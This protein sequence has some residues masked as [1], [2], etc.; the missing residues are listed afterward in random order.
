MPRAPLRPDGVRFSSI[1]AAVLVSMLATL[2]LGGGVARAA[3]G[4]LNTGAYVTNGSVNAVVTAPDGSTYIGGNFS[5]VGPRIGEGFP[6][7]ESPSDITPTFGPGEP[8]PSAFPEVSGG[9]VRAVVADGSGG[10]YIGGNFDHVGGES[11]V[12]LAH[13]SGDGTVDTNWNASATGGTNGVEALAISAGTLYVAGDFTQVNSTARNG[14]AAV[15]TADPGSLDSS[16]NPNANGEVRALA[17]SPDSLTVYAAGAFTS[18]GGATRNHI[19]ALDAAGVNGGAGNA[20]SGWDPNANGEVHALAV[21]SGGTVYAGGSFN[22]I[23]GASRANLAALAAGNGSALSAWSTN[24][25]TN[26]SVEALALSPSDGTVFAGGTFT[27]VGGASHVRIAALD[28][29]NGTPKSWAPQLNGTVRALTISG[30]FVYAGGDFTTVTDEGSNTRLRNHV[31]AISI[32]DPLAAASVW[33]PNTDAAAIALAAGGGRV[34]IGGNFVTAGSQVADRDNL[35]R[36]NADGTLDTGWAP[37]GTDGPVKALALAAPNADTLY[38]G[39]SFQNVSGLTRNGLAALK[40]SDASLYSWDP[41]VSGGGA[42]VRAL[43]LS[44]NGQTLYAGGDF[45]T[46]HGTGRTDL[47]ALAADASATAT[48]NSWNPNVTGTSVD[49]LAV[50]PNGLGLTAPDGTVYAGGTF[51]SIGGASLTDV[52]ALDPGTASAVSG[53]T[54]TA[55]GPVKALAVAPDDGTVYAG[56]TYTSIGGQSRNR[57]GALDPSSGAASGWDPNASGEV[58]ALGIDGGIV[59]AGGLFASVGGS[60]RTNIAAIK[61]SNGQAAAWTPSPAGRVRA[62][63]PFPSADVLYAGGDFPAVTDQSL[64]GYAAA[65][66]ASFEARPVGVSSSPPGGIGGSGTQASPYNYGNVLVGTST[67]SKTFTITN[68]GFSDLVIGTVSLIGPQ[69]TEFSKG[70]D[71]CQSSTV[72]PGGTCTIAV[73]FSPAAIGVKNAQIEFTD[74]APGGLSDVYLRGIGV[75]PVSSIAPTSKDMGTIQVGSSSATQT[76]TVSNPGGWPLQVTSVAKIGANPSEFAIVAD[77]CSGQTVNPGTTCTVQAAFRPTTAAAASATL[78]FT[79]NGDASLS[80][81]ACSGSPC[82]QDVGLTGTGTLGAPDAQLSPPQLSFGSRRVGS[83]QSAAQTTTLTNGGLADLVISSAAVT[84]PDANQFVVTANNCDATTLIGGSSCSV[85]VAFLPTSAGSKSAQIQF[86][87][88]ASG[89][90][91]LVALSGSGNSSGINLPPI[92][93]VLDTSIGKGPKKTTKQKTATFTFS[94]NAGGSTFQCKVDKK[95][96]KPCHPPLK[97]KRLKAG[98]HTFQVRAVNGGSTDGSP[99]SYRWKVKKKR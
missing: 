7:A 64:R 30:E 19:G 29:S 50:L 17:I 69:H 47:A 49:A 2:C 61:R 6:T 96:W 54:G 79:S 71:T 1:R 5:K 75:V 25:N 99:A 97:L 20:V 21:A 63:V 11:H 56:G 72:G 44:P 41:N 24:A 68:T 10:W 27:T 52:A 43:A 60:S 88:N 73:T 92:S 40:P 22:T 46:V 48:V 55:N 23:G 18:I 37:Q 77:N 67:P 13:I 98:K 53:W 36:L 34:Y 62:L 26:Y 78:E 70:T 81:P 45:T 84:G 80:V 93:A 65:H 94:A 86:D 31:A 82:V 66:L 51:S 28:P 3:N 83:G 39:G 57:L 58:D 89:T 59:Y 32:S 87:D 95:P 33:D 15:D 12:G 4:D 42:E 74:N 90:P 91:H 85:S 16:W 14:I 9:S 35:A 76:F 8:D 38:V